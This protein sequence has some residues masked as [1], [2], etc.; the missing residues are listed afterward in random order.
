[1]GGRVVDC[2]R[3]E[4]VYTERYRGFES[5]PIRSPSVYAV[6]R[7]FW[8]PKTA[9]CDKKCD[10]VFQLLPVFTDV[11]LRVFQSVFR[12]VGLLFC[13]ADFFVGGKGAAG[14]EANPAASEAGRVGAVWRSFA[15]A[16]VTNRPPR[17]TQ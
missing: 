1:M 16:Q 3:L 5:P 10:N 4:S 13:P 8:R 11:F 6:P 15:P 2:A 12:F 17:R 9:K 7:V 14:S